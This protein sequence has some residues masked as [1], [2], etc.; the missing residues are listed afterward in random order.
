M[1][2]PI[3]TDK[4]VITIIGAGAVAHALAPAL[5]K[6]GFEINTIISRTFVS[7]QALAQ[8]LPN[9][10]P[11]TEINNITANCVI[12]AVNDQSIPIVVEQLSKNQNVVYLHTAGSVP[13]KVL[14][15][16]G[17][18]I[19][20]IYPLQT[21]TRDRTINWQD[22]PIFIEANNN[23]TLK[24]VQNLAQRLSYKVQSLDSE[25][26]FGLHLGAVF[27]SNF[28]NYLLACAEN[29]TGRLPV[30]YAVYLPLLEESI[31]KLQSLN[32]IAA[33][34]GPAKRGDT[35]TLLQHL[36]YLQENNPDLV[37]IYRLLSAQILQKYHPDVKLVI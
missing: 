21:F 11:T 4:I 12:L 5:V 14:A 15:P 27:V 36:D 37:P 23:E 34:T 29:I 30:D 33:Q 35:N 10:N 19:G 2:I 24:I 1:I 16:L 6:Q 9:A 20:V 26:R 8:K 28:V 22:V 31:A 17:D 25:Q 18:N 13:L 32:P 7:A 3:D